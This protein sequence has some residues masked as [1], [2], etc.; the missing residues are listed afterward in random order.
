MPSLTRYLSAI[1][2][3]SPA[4]GLAA[5]TAL[6]PF[7]LGAVGPDCA[8]GPLKSNKICDLSADPAERASAL[9]AAMTQE[10][11]LANLVR[12]VPK[13]SM[14]QIPNS[15]PA[16]SLL[17]FPG[18]DFQHTIGGEKLFMV[19]VERP[20]LAFP[21]TSKLRL[22]FQCQYSWL[23]PLMIILSTRLRQ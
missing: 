5:V 21:V 4:I 19:L 9:V 10:E 6:V 11:K 17:A 20:G 18:S 7:V 16:A 12:Y 3:R 23:L 15:S 1:M 2:V 8:N 13:G 22:P 14:I